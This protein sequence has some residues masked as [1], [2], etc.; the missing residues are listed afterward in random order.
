[1]LAEGKPDLVLAFPGD[2]GTRDIRSKARKA[3]V[4]VLDID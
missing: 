4:T 1:M 2:E 3:G